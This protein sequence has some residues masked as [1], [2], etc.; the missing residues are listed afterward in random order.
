M[1]KIKKIIVPSIQNFHDPR[2]V[3][4]IFSCGDTGKKLTKIELTLSHFSHF[5]E[6]CVYKVGW[7]LLYI[8][9]P[10]KKNIHRPPLFPCKTILLLDG[11]GK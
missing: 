5:S 11:L 4:N 10:N 7:R 6:T 2:I 3:K 9:T 8:Y 1:K